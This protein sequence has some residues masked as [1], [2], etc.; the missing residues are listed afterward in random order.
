M[1]RAGLTYSLGRIE[2]FFSK[3]QTVIRTFAIWISG[4][5]KTFLESFLPKRNLGSV[6]KKATK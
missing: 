2:R 5:L 6:S 1:D 3:M 4:S